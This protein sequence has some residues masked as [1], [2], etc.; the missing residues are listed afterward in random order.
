VTLLRAA[1]EQDAAALLPELEKIGGQLE[2]EDIGEVGRLSAAVLMMTGR[3]RD[4]LARAE[5]ALQWARLREDGQPGE[6]RLFELEYTA[7]LAANGEVARAAAILRDLSS[8]DVGASA[9]QMLATAAAYEW[10]G[11]ECTDDLALR[12]AVE[13]AARSSYFALLVRAPTALAQLCNVAL[14]RELEPGFVLALIRARRLRPPPAVCRQWPFAVRVTSLGAFTL[15]LDGERYQPVHKA[16]DKVLELLKVLVAAQMLLRGPAE[17][18]WLCDRL[19]PDSEIEKARKSLEMSVSRLRKLL[20]ADAAVVVSEGKVRLNEELVWTDVSELLAAAGRLA[21]LRD[22]GRR[23]ACSVP[24]ARVRR[25]VHA[26]LDLYGGPF[27]QGEDDAPWVIGV[28]TLLARVLRN[29]LADSE[30]LLQHVGLD[31][32]PDLLERALLLDPTSEEMARMLMQHHCR[33][34]EYAEA[35]R[36]YRRCAD[37]LMAELGVPPSAATEL[38]KQQVRRAATDDSARTANP[39]I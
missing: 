18:T 34:G 28:R 3:P 30:Q 1:R 8:R 9:E 5:A 37:M 36:V 26:L 31:A 38:L 7:A 25:D 24:I 6:I 32:P 29:A 35:L 2:D 15:E 21:A 10:L 11:S 12:A 27:A 20:R 4:A 23:V 17:R 22:E 16:Q 14:Q 39:R 13:G 19:W 33:R